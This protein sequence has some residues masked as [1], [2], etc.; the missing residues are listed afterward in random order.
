VTRKVNHSDPELI[1][2]AV[3]QTAPA[4]MHLAFTDEPEMVKQLR[5][6]VTM[7][8]ADYKLWDTIRKSYASHKTWKRLISR[9]MWLTA[10]VIRT[11]RSLVDGQEIK[12]RAA[13]LE[14]IPKQIQKCRKC[15]CPCHK[16]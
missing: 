7:S 1:K 8:Q 15:G 9:T 16:E 4:L 6:V 10:R 11:G 12:W 14:T 5:V 13:G 2:A 3:D